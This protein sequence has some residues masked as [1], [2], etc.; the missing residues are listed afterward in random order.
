MTRTPL[1]AHLDTR[2]RSLS[3]LLQPFPSLST[4][5]A[6][7]PKKQA[8]AAAAAGAAT[9]PAT[10]A[11]APA[12]TA[13]GTAAH[14]ASP[15]TR[16]SPAKPATPNSN[17]ASPA[18]KAAAPPPFEFAPP[19]NA[20]ELTLDNSLFFTVK[21]IFHYLSQFGF[22]EA[23]LSQTHIQPP[24]LAAASSRARPSLTHLSSGCLS[25]R[26]LNCSTQES[27]GGPIPGA[28]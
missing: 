13:N 10:P 2:H 21:A 12:P 28:R 17:H 5:V 1:T 16:K 24:H 27:S 8:A 6:M 26:I 19:Q 22:G 14:G 20:S 23:A 3:R 7:P 4:A 11:P 18:A 15:S 25:C 9:A